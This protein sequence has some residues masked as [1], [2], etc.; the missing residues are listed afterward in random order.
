M[1]R[2]FQLLSQILLLGLLAVACNHEEI[3]PTPPPEPAQWQA[4]PEVRLDKVLCE[5]MLVTENKLYVVGNNY[6]LTFNSKHQLESSYFL[7]SQGITLDNG[8]PFM[9]K[10]FLAYVD[11]LNQKINIHLINKPQVSTQIDIKSL[12]STFRLIYY[13]YNQKVA[14]NDQDELLIP[15]V[16]GIS[17]TTAHILRFQLFTNDNNINA[18]HQQSV[19]F[20]TSNTGFHNLKNVIAHKNNFIFSIQF[21]GTFQALP[22]GAIQ[23]INNITSPYLLKTQDSTFVMGYASRS[24]E[25]F[26]V[27]VGVEKAPNVWQSFKTSFKEDGGWLRYTTID[28]KIMS[29]FNRNLLQ[30]S[31]D[32]GKGK[33]YIKRISLEGLPPYVA[34]YDV[35]LF[36]D[37]VYVTTHNG[38]YSKPLKDF[39]VY[40]KE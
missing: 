8:R 26:S 9:N 37:K 32:L 3:R 23:K 6:L 11:N 7:S 20:A 10:K 39:F 40:E 30:W 36:K 24:E 13:C 27:L 2:P 16:S 28:N 31:L 29:F 33:Y 4:H 18:V 5:N 34:I 1:F 14:I 35:A 12:D 25:N 19:V 22:D 38:L 17:N 15:V 21:E